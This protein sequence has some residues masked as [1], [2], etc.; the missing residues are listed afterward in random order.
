MLGRLLSLAS[1]Y[2]QN[3]IQERICILTRAV[4]V[5]RVKGA[6]PPSPSGSCPTSTGFRQVKRSFQLCALVHDGPNSSDSH[7]L[8]L[9]RQSL[10]ES[11]VPLPTLAA[12][13]TACA[14]VAD[15]HPA[16]CTRLSLGATAIAAAHTPVR[17]L[18]AP[19]AAERMELLQQGIPRSALDRFWQ[20]RHSQ[21]RLE[22]AGRQQVAFGRPWRRPFTTS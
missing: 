7:P 6:A 10:P 3:S 9:P 15:V 5:G 18:D 2:P 11:A 17:R 14:G 12:A 20:A 19:S 8:A 4:P 1:A 22:S 16:C 13:F 21:A